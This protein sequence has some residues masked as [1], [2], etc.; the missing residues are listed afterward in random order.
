[1]KNIFTIILAM[2][3]ATSMEAQ[4]E[5]Y[6]L[7]WDLIAVDGIEGMTTNRLYLNTTAS[8]D[9]LTSVSGWAGFESM[10]QTTTSFY[11]NENGWVSPNS[12]V[13]ELNTTVGLRLASMLHRWAPTWKWA[14]ALSRLRPMYGFF[15]SR[16]GA[17][18]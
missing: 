1:M 17:I 3:I 2:A 13:S 16:Q 11:Q 10:V 14:S 12:N 5:S 8:D 15:L 9:F 4:N 7:S 18:C 6:F